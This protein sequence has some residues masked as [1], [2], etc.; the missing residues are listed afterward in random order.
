MGSG[1]RRRESP[2]KIPHREDEL[3]RHDA[4]GSSVGVPPMTPSRAVWPP[5]G[6]RLD[7]HL[8]GPFCRFAREQQCHSATVSVFL[9][10]AFGCENIPI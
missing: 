10:P 1:N 3:T 4:L 8:V 2:D 7:Q 5:I 9:D 6:V